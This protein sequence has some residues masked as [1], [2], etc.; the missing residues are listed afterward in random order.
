[1]PH[2]EAA[3]LDFYP[4]QSQA[5]AFASQTLADLGGP[6]AKGVALQARIFADQL[7]KGA[8]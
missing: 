3:Y 4:K 1:M 8:R 7:E 6:E 5:I 2:S